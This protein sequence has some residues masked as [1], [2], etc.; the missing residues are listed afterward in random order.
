MTGSGTTSRQAVPDRSRQVF[1]HRA[2]FG[3]TAR[4]FSEGN[5][6]RRHVAETVIRLVRVALWLAQCE[7]PRTLSCSARSAA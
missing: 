6:L 2:G 3:G 5:V 1:A 7:R 4:V